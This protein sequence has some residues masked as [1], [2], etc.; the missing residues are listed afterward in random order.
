MPDP[1]LDA[2]ELEAA[3]ELDELV[4]AF[5]VLVVGV[6]VVPAAVTDGDLVVVLSVGVEPSVGVVE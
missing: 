1:E 3:E 5:V 6:D 4:L 2:V